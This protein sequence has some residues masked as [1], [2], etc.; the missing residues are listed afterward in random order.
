MQTRTCDARGVA[1]TS[2]DFPSRSGRCRECHRGSMRE[3]HRRNRGYY[4]AM[5]RARQVVVIEQTRA[6]L[7]HYLQEHPCVDCGIDDPL[8]LEFD[9]RDPAEKVA[10]VAVLA[11]SGFPL[12]R[13]VAE[14]GKC[15]VRCAN[16]HRRRT[17][18]KRGW[19]GSAHVK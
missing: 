5:A 7:L 13:V 4:L 10:S 6:F 11:R 19:W 2:R 12:P 8:V 14:V 1:Q 3:H 18:V 17:H 16:C 9:H 15:D